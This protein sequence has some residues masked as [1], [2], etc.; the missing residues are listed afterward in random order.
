MVVLVVLEVAV[1]MVPTQSHRVLMVKPAVTEVVV[2]PVVWVVRLVSVP[3]SV[4]VA[5]VVLLV[6][7]VMV[8][9]VL[10]VMR[11]RLLAVRAVLVVIRVL[12][13]VLVLRAVEQ[14]LQARMVLPVRR[15]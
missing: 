9:T 15:L 4:M 1:L 11:G 7:L 14:E 8:V 5:T 3:T 2:A 10:L 6:R 12:Q 13:A